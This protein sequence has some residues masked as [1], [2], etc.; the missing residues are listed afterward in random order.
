MPFRCKRRQGSTEVIVYFPESS[1]GA[2][3]PYKAD[4]SH[5]GDA[6]VLCG[7]VVNVSAADGRGIGNDTFDPLHDV[8]RKCHWSAQRPGVQLRAPALTE[9][10]TT[11]ATGARGECPRAKWSNSTD[12]PAGARQLQCPCWAASRHGALSS[13]QSFGSSGR[14]LE[15]SSLGQLVLRRAPNRH[16]PAQ[17]AE[18]RATQ[19]GRTG[20]HEVWFSHGRG[21]E[22]SGT[23]RAGTR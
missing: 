1:V 12:G 14:T 7:L 10:D 3:D 6:A 23:S 2:N 21:P 13:L 22:E 5:Q 9:P 17:S 16:G 15:A 11:T 8:R 20:N 18:E 4:R 19:N